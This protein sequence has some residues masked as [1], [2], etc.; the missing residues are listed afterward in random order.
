M[1]TEEHKLDNP[2]WNSLNEFHERFSIDH[3]GV[4]IYN[5]EYCPFGG[6]KSTNDLT[7]FLDSLPLLINQIYVFGVNPLLKGKLFLSKEINCYQMILK[8]S[9]DKDVVEEI[10]ELKSENQEKDLLNLVHSV[11][12]DMLQNKSSELGK[13]FGIYKNKKLIAVIGERMKMNKYTE[14]S[15]IV[16]H[17]E[18]MGKGYA[19]QLIKHATDKIFK[20]S[21]TP[22]LH[23][24][25]SNINAIELYKNLGFTIRRKISCW[26][27]ESNL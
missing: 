27:L 20:E 3:K 6:L 26:S 10:I 12:P 1:K 15:S 4:K 18:H 22:Y 8:K 25:I 7:P 13:Y 21:K 14:I 24:D 11:L 19:K 2:V 16:T 23:V 9:I 5:P 17:S